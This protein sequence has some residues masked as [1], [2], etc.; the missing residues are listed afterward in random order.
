[1]APYLTPTCDVIAIDLPGHGDSEVASRHLRIDDYADGVLA[2]LDACSI[3]SATILGASV[4]GQIATAM[5]ARHAE[6]VSRV[7]LCETN[8]RPE[9]WWVEN[10]RRV[11]DRFALPIEDASIV[12]ALLRDPSDESVAR[13]NID[14]SKAGARH[15]M[16]VMWAIREY[17]MATDLGRVEAP[18]LLV[19]GTDGP[20][21]GGRDGLETDLGAD[22]VRSVVLSG[23]GHFPM[24]DVPEDF[25]RVV[26]AE[27]PPATNGEL[28]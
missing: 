3:R 9:A 18:V 10:W 13:W 28:T 7:V 2:V 6:R 19:F 1:M 23:S 4:G 15:M 11:E 5:A 12:R 8:Y 16:S 26:M 25:A 27:A 24:H 21:L 17:E 22:E 14:R 20:A